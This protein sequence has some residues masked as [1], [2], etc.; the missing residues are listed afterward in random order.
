MVTHETVSYWTVCWKWIF[1]YPCKKYRDEWCYNFK[2]VKEY[3]WLFFCYNN[4]CMD[5]EKYTWYSPCVNVFGTETFYNIKL[6]FKKRKTP[7]GTC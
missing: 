3:R 2:R 5:G 6:C 7:S 1:P 4:G